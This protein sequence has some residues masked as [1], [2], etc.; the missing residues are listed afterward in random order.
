MHHAAI[1]L[2]P[3]ETIEE[4][5]QT[6]ALQR[7][8]WPGSETDVTPAH[9]ALAISHHGGVVI[10]A[11]DGERL[12]GYVIGF[13][14]TDRHSPGRVA[15]A[16][17]KH[18]S[19]QLAVD[20]EYHG[21]GIGVALKKAQREAVMRQGIRLI[22]WTYDP[23]L[24]LNAYLNVRKLGV[25]CNTYIENAYGQM[26]DGLNVGIPS[27]R[28]EVDWWITSRRVEERLRGER[29]PLDLAHF[30][31]AGAE[32][33]NSSRL[34]EDGLPYPSGQVEE[35]AG[36]L[37]LVEIPPDFLRLK[38]QAPEVALSW[39]MHTREIFQHLFKAGYMVVD[40]ISLREE[41][42][43]RSYYLLAHGEGTLG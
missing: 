27:D 39:R 18:Y 17:L 9:V 4:M 8:V 33:V 43:P 7:K 20:P 3:L 38:Q 19:H 35:P 15:M 10:G 32:K 42:F 6:E 2:R 30:L 26:R 40:F 5:F 37:V 41:R 21:R 12:V 28:F 16:R 23:L 36:N 1:E 14:G 31:G 11:F 24:S 25:V 22:T 29:A 34:A 13:I